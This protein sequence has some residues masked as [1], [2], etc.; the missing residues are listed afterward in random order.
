MRKILFIFSLII[1]SWS[2]NAQ[3]DVALVEKVNQ[4]NVATTMQEYMTLQKDFEKM[5]GKTS[6]QT[7]HYYYYAA[8]SSFYQGVMKAEDGSD[9]GAHLSF[10]HSL[11]YLYAIAGRYPNNVEINNLIGMNYFLKSKID[12]ERAS[13]LKNKAMEYYNAGKEIDAQNPRNILLGNL[14]LS[15]NQVIDTYKKGDSPL[16]PSWGDE[17]LGNL[18]Q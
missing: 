9:E 17:N 1:G 12:M 15:K 2:V 16:A 6:N 10:D 5:Y 11:K 13:L 4:L 7:W 18:I 14:L 3:A 8:L